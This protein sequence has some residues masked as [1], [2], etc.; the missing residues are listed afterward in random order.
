MTP[1]DLTAIRARCEALGKLRKDWDA[2]PVFARHAEGA[3]ADQYTQKI[4][5]EVWRAKESLA[6]RD[7]SS[8]VPLLLTEIDRL[9]ALVEAAYKEGWNEGVGDGH[10]LASRTDSEKR[11]KDSSAHFDVEGE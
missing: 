1:A 6:M 4:A 3:T 9:R 10:P 11:W 7:L 2:D 8:D 5:M